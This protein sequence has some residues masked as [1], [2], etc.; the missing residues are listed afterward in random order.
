MKKKTTPEVI[1]DF[2]RE[3]RAGFIEAIFGAGKT[4]K[5]VLNIFN[6]FVST[7][8]CALAT[9]CSKKTISLLKSEIPGC[10]TDKNSGLAWYP[11]K[12]DVR[13]G[14]AAVVAAGTSDISVAEEA[15]IT[16][17]FG[18]AEVE[19]IY[20]VGVAGIHRLFNCLDKIKNAEV[21]IVVA[22]ME[23]ALPSVVGGLVSAPVIAVPTS[24]GYGA[25]FHGLAALLGMLNSCS[26]GVTVTN[27][28]NGF[29]A[30]VAAIR[31]LKRSK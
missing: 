8:G 25:S 23:G 27:I 1:P 5:Q 21:V 19:R 9:R 16:L 14:K 22:G 24:V 13:L 20:D 7:K 2:E 30:A 29:G 11:E 12:F 4:S 17:E 31:I 28:D 10:C 3:E 6:E 26:A 15:A 18:G